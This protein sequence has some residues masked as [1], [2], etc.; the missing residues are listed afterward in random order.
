MTREINS[1]M[2]SFH[3]SADE[4]ICLQPPCCRGSKLDSEIGSLYVLNPR[5]LFR[6]GWVYLQPLEVE[7]LRD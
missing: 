7:G 5:K 2:I 6:E 3:S 4:Y 1:A